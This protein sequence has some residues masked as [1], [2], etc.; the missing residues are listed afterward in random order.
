MDSH[1][2]HAV[3]QERLHEARRETEAY[4]LRRA[5][6]AT[7]RAARADRRAEVAVQRLTV[8]LAR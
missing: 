5:V 2:S 6:R 4:R 1:W 3:A 7:R 8:A